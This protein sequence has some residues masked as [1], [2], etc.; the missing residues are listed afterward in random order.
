K[1]NKKT[2]RLEASWAMCEKAAGGHG[3]IVLAVL[4]LLHLTDVKKDKYGKIVEFTNLTLLNLWILR[5]GGDKGL[6]EDKA[7][8]GLVALQLVSGAIGLFIRHSLALL[9]FWEDNLGTPW[10]P[11]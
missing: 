9:V 11:I 7:M 3:M 6:R 1:L 5:V 8:W 2:G 4:D 10:T